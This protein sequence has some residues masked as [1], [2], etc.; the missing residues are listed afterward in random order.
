MDLIELA[1]NYPDMNITIRLGDLMIAA[2]K[3]LA[4][5]RRDARHEALADAAEEKA[6]GLIPRIKVAH[7]LNVNLTT[8][9]K[10]NKQ[11]ILP[12]VKIGTKVMY[13][14]EDLDRLIKNKRYPTS[15]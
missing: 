7:R 5:A 11:G 3:L 1:R 15:K 8:L 12:A 2:N 6:E 10:W 13:R 9:W 4:E 14:P